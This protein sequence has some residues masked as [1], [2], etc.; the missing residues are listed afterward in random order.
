MILRF[1]SHGSCLILHEM[2]VLGIV[3]AQVGLGHGAE[4]GTQHLGHAGALV[5]F[6]LSKERGST[7]MGGTVW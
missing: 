3:P 6:G 2:C 5:T 7:T 4:R 1:Y